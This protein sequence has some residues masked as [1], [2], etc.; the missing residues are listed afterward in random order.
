MH[1]LL[2]NKQKKYS[3]IHT[4]QDNYIFGGHIYFKYG[5]KYTLILV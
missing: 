3:S 2:V 4:L 1:L 5:K